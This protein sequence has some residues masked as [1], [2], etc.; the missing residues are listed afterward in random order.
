MNYEFKGQK[1]KEQKKIGFQKD[2]CKEK[3]TDNVFDFKAVGQLV[4]EGFKKASIVN[5]AG[6]QFKLGEQSFFIWKS[7]RELRSRRVVVEGYVSKFKV[8]EKVAEDELDMVLKQLKKIGLI[9]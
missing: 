2:A 5:P 4:D 1:K 8:T 9:Q 3:M 7:I 6:Q